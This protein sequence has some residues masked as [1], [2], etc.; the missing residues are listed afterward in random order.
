MHPWICAVI[1]AEL[2]QEW[3]ALLAQACHGKP[4]VWHNHAVFMLIRVST[5]WH[6]VQFTWYVNQT[7][8]KT[9][10]VGSAGKWRLKFQ[11]YFSCAK[12]LRFSFQSAVSCF[13]PDGSPASRLALSC[14]PSLFFHLLGDPLNANLPVIRA[15]SSPL[16]CQFVLHVHERLLVWSSLFPN[17]F[18]SFC[19]FWQSI[20]PD[21]T[22]SAKAHNPV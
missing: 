22:H 4:E 13:H 1:Q 6:L 3:E 15:E 10:S 20:K 11:V 17:V 12:F 8:N 5:R 18:L 19:T 7:G 2:R 16:L 9:E 14:F 21:Q